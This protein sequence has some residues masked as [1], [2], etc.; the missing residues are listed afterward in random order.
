MKRTVELAHVRQLCNLGLPAE[1]VMPAFLRAVRALVPAGFGAFFWVDAD[2]EMTNMY[3]EKM[4]PAEVT[5]RYFREHYQSAAHAFRQQVMAQIADGVPVAESTA[6]AAMLAT[7]YYR[8]VLAPLGAARML[9]AV[10]HDRGRPLGQLSLYR[11]AGARR[12]ERDDHDT[13]A[14]AARYLLPL[15]M[16]APAPQTTAP[17]QFRET[18][19]AALLMCDADGQVRRASG[20]G[21]ALLAQASGCRINRDTITCELERAGVALLRRLTAA[22]DPDDTLDDAQAADRIVFNDWGAFRLR[23]YPIDT[24]AGVLIERHEHL[25]VRLVDAMG[26]SALSSQQREVALLIARGLTNVQVAQELGVSANTASYHVRQLFTKLDAHDRAEV[27]ARVL[28]RHTV[29]H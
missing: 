4:L 9:R 20:R 22:L 17:E 26:Q 23:A 3:S 25:L 5:S 28:D 12:F 18:G 2:G 27:I 11:P 19:Q 6:D 13:V 21:H 29:R 7:P 16:T 1:A 10:L 8:E 14:S 15:L 24:G